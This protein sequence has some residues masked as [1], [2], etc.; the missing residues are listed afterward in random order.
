MLK[1]NLIS[2]PMQHR[3][4]N[5]RKCPP[6]SIGETFFFMIMH[7][8]FQQESSWSVLPYLPYSRDL[9]S[10]YYYL[11]HAVNDKNFLMKIRGKSLKKI[12]PKPAEFHSIRIN[13]LSEKWQQEVIQNNGNYTINGK[14]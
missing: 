6:S 13:K 7:G 11:F 2:Q 5:L 1:A 3:L 8:H 9:A 14:R 10:S 12:S 4:E